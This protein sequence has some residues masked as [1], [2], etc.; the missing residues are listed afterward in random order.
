M[1]DDDTR[2]HLSV[3]LLT[4]LSVSS[5]MV[6]VCLTAIGIIGVIKASRRLETVWDDLMVVDAVLFLSAAL[7]SFLGL[8]TPLRKRER[9]I[10]VA[11]D[12][13]FCVGLILMV[14]TCGV[15]VW[16]VL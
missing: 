4:M 10:A 3:H 11:V 6:G 8:R 12:C 13:T 14:A 5:G 16:V 7:L 1:A 15:L 9:A 2:Q